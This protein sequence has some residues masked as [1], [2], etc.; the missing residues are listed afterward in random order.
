MEIRTI[1]TKT[2]DEFVLSSQKY[3]FMQT[4]AWAEV[5]RSRGQK[6]HQLGFYEGD[7]LKATALL[8]EKKIGPFASFY[9]PRGMACDYSDRDLLASILK[10]TKEYIRKRNGLYFRFD[11]DLLWHVLNQDNSIREDHPENEELISFFQSQGCKWR[12]RTMSFREMSNPRF[13]VRTPVGGDEK[14]LIKQCH[15]TM[16]RVLN[17]HNPYHLNVYKGNEEDVLYYYETMQ[18]TAKSK[19]ILLEPYS[20]FEDFYKI[21]NAHGMADIWVCRA[22]LGPIRKIYEDQIRTLEQNENRSEDQDR[23]LN[24]LLSEKEQLDEVKEEEVVLSSIIC[25]KLKDKVWT[26]HIGNN[27][28][29]RFLHGS[30]EIYFAVLKDA[31]AHNAVWV[32][33]FGTEGE[34][35]PG[36]DGYGIHQFKMLFG[37]NYDEFIGEFD[38]VA[39]PL[40]NALLGK[41]LYLR[42]RWLIRRSVKENHGK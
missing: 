7:T 39:R 41:L 11:P 27:D 23:Q 4:S 3:H 37:G 15:N 6:A 38:L 29:L 20:F 31:Q 36:T 30:H 22:E 12:G 19:D 16:R 34:V 10:L 25:A 13:T 9:C 17:K 18:A 24:R 32:D 28:I 35:K 1:D 2:L 5:A 8:L 42:R 26:V 33:F 40:T 14:S 21:L